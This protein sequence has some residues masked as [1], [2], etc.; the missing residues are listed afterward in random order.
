[1]I[2]RQLKIDPQAAIIQVAMGLE[3]APFRQLAR[4]EA[5][6]LKLG[7]A[8]FTPLSYPID[9]PRQEILLVESAIGI[10]NAA[11]ASATAFSLVP[12]A[13][14]VISAGTAGGLRS[15]VCVGDL[16]LGSSY[17]YTDS[18]ATAFGYAY[19][20][21]PGMPE[22]YQADPQLL[23]IASQ[24]AADY[25]GPGKIHIGR[26]LAGSSFVTAHNVA[27]TRQLFP[28]A[29]STD[30]ETTAIAQVCHTYALPFIAVR[31]I[32]DLCAPSADQDFHLEADIVAPRSAQLALAIL[33]QASSNPPHYQ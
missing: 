5:E 13:R 18:D 31:G 23:N 26:M 8:S 16:V 22:S 21:V 4:A 17:S 9:R 2:G 28:Q 1:M 3:A 20:Q 10:A 12:Q 19:G 29:L 15:D 33:E 6:T 30:M 27:Q 7:K 25:S 11:A 32:S 14:L 24:L